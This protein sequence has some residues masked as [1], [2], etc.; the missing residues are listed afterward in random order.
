MQVRVRLLGILSFDY[1]AYRKFCPVE[2]REGENVKG[3][4]ERLAL[5][6]HKIHFVSVNGKMVGDD[7]SLAEGD[8]IIFVP[9][10]SGG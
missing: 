6:E 1:P 3:L 9:A 4:R 10:A 5:P 7:F 2:L 8:E